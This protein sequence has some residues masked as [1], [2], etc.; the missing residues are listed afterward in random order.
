MLGCR[1]ELGG[2]GVIA[3]TWVHDGTRGTQIGGFVG[4]FYQLSE[5]LDNLLQAI[6]FD[7]SHRLL[8]VLAERGRKPKREQWPIVPLHCSKGHSRS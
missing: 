4:Y 7:E 5:H 6:V 3:I 8:E 2:V 1:G